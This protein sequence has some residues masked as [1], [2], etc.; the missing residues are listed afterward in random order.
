MSKKVRSDQFRN[1]DVDK[2]DEDQ[3]EDE[4]TTNLE[5]AAQF[6]DREA[7]VKSL[8]SQGN[9]AGALPI[10]LESPPAGSSDKSIKERNLSLVLDVVTRFKSADVEKAVSTLDTDQQDILMKYI[11][12]G[13]AGG[14]DKDYPILLTFHEKV[15]KLGGLGCIMRVLTDRKTV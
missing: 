4:E 15:Y 6:T 13:F 7:R 8:I 2:Y 3:Y 12:K 5:A 14:S 11:Y 9:P 1:A 10:V